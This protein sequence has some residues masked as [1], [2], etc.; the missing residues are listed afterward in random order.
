MDDRTVIKAYRQIL[1][2]L[3]QRRLA[4]A[5]GT[6]T[7][8]IDETGEW[9]LRDNC[10]RQRTI[11]KEMLRYVVQGI[12]DPQR[13][14]IHADV[15]EAIYRLADDAK[16]ALLLRSSARLPYQKMRLAPAESLADLCN[17]CVSAH[18]E[19]LER[20]ERRLF[21]A[22]WLSQRWTDEETNVLTDWLENVSAGER[23]KCL[24]VSAV[25]LSALRFYDS[26]KMALLLDVCSSLQMAVKQRAVVGVVLVLAFHA[27]RIAIDRTI[28]ARLNLL[29]ADSGFVGEL[30]SAYLQL[31]RTSETEAV[32]DRIR[33]EIMPAMVRAT[34]KISDKLSDILSCDDDDDRNPDWQEVLDDAGLTDKVQEFSEMQ[35]AGADVYAATFAQL[36]SY[37][38]F[39]ETA[40][41]LLPFDA[42]HSSVAG[43]LDGEHNVFAAIVKMPF[44]CDSD[45]YSLCFSLLQ[46]PAG[47]RRVMLNGIDAESEQAQEMLADERFA[48]PEITTQNVANQY[49]QNLYRLYTQHPRRA[50]FDN[51]LAAVLAF[52]KT[53]LFARIFSETETRMQIADFYFSKELFADSA[54]QFDTLLADNPHD[55][56]LLQKLGYCY[57]KMADYDKAVVA[58]SR[59]DLYL[60][61]NFWTL[62]RLAFCQRRLGHIEQ[63]LEAYVACERLQ[64]DNFKILLQKGHCLVELKRYKDAVETY[65]RADNIKPDDA[66]CRRAVA[67]CYLL[68]GQFGKA[69]KQ[70]E[71]LTAS[72]PRGDDWLNMGHT[73]FLLGERERATACYRRSLALYKSHSDFFAALSADEPVLLNLGLSPDEILA[74]SDLLKLA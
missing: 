13:E 47:Q 7:T 20:A 6:L 36:K 52:Y 53:D 46:V 10:E 35:F 43:F 39:G 22:V 65:F 64:P 4:D 59:S 26:R 2:D 5:I 9:S 16:A 72:E 23:S 61:D 63:A 66:V 40:N 28:A 11:Y 18:G 70:Y 60:P 19:M 37:P 21:D 25:T 44:L 34:P 54:A 55:G 71:R 8:L 31:V 69:L 57:Q 17:E 50:D 29:T 58:Y 30:K 41:W 67:W 42:T 38:F 68:D 27:H 15:T 1:S 74:L 51:P 73:C 14:A 32:A 12:D 45:K 56:A 33:N 24:V 49:V 62:R 3:S 48:H